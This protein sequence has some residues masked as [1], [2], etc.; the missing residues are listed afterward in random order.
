MLIFRQLKLLPT[1]LSMFMSWISAIFIL[2]STAEMYMY[3]TQVSDTEKMHLAE[4]NQ[5]KS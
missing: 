4:R 3:G 5:L 2:G 1:I